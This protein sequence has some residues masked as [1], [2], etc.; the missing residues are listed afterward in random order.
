MRCYGCSG[1]G[2]CWCQRLLWWKEEYSIRPWLACN[3]INWSFSLP[4]IT[5]ENVGS[6]FGASWGRHK[7]TILCPILFL[8]LSE[9]WAVTHSG[10]PPIISWSPENDIQWISKSI[11]LNAFFAL[12]WLVWPQ[13]YSWTSGYWWYLFPRTGENEWMCNLCLIQN[14][15]TIVFFEMSLLW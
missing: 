6:I 12:T 4:W 2:R 3:R 5:V 9:S 11:S 8:F 15:Q 7:S 1:G 13:C 10:C 14:I